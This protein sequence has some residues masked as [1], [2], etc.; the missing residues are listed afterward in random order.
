MSDGKTTKAIISKTVST[1][2]KLGQS[3]GDLFQETIETQL[4]N[5]PEHRLYGF[6]NA[7]MIAGLI[8]WFEPDKLRVVRDRSTPV[9]QLDADPIFFEVDQLKCSLLRRAAVITARHG[10]N[11]GNKVARYASEREFDVLETLKLIGTHKDGAIGA[12]KGQSSIR[13][14]IPIVRR[15]MR[16]KYNNDEILEALEVLASAQHLLRIKADQKLIESESSILPIFMRVDDN[17]EDGKSFD[18]HETTHLCVLHPLIT[19]AISNLDM[20][21]LNSSAVI[22]SRSLLVRYMRKRLALRWTQA[23]ASTPYGI[24]A[25]TILKSYGYNT[26]LEGKETFKRLARPVDRALMTLSEGEGAIIS[27]FET[28]EVHLLNQKTGR[29]KIVDFKYTIYPKKEFV[30]EQ[31]RSLALRA[32]KEALRLQAEELGV[33]PSQL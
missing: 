19:S 2:A 1:K 18:T 6:S 4:F 17:Y 13:F 8:P 22:N 24:L 32:E 20:H 14:T 10:P 5:L 16:N 26:T 31:K 15:Y 27:H 7:S 21:Q 3:N 28:E 11:K 30:K 33:K 29:K 12:F 23:S 25:T 9:D